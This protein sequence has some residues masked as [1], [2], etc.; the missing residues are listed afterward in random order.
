MLTELTEG[1]SNTDAASVDTASFTPAVGQLFFITGKRTDSGSMASDDWVIT[2]TGSTWDLVTTRLFTGTSAWRLSVYR[3]SAAG[4]AAVAAM[5]V[6]TAV[7][8]NR[9][10]WSVQE[11]SAPLTG[12]V[13]QSAVAS[14]TFSA[15]AAVTLAA[16]ADAGNWT[17]MFSSADS[18]HTTTFED[19]TWTALTNIDNLVGAFKE[20]EDTSPT[21]TLSGNRSWGAIG[22]EL[23]ASTGA[24]A[25]V[26]GTLATGTKTQAD[27][28]AGGQT[29]ILTLTGDTFLTPFDSTITAAL[30]AGVDAASSPATGWNTVVRDAAV[31]PIT[32]VRTSATVATGTLAA[33]PSYAI[34]ADEV[35]TVTIPASA[36][37]GGVAIIA[38]PTITIH[39]GAVLSAYSGTTNGSGVL[40][41][42][43]T[44]DQAGILVLTRAYIGAT[45]VG[46]ITT[47]PT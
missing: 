36:L 9:R 32:W 44:S 45:E 26:T 19:G 2:Q 35:L 40:A 25:A 18:T 1:T 11:P 43:L 46:R 47:L 29:I 16:F 28:K 21:F 20:S 27:V 14:N 15:S 3:C 23:E 13:V 33:N 4:S 17:V 34:T 10:K 7:N 39:E 30:T 6:D 22:L 24:T 5:S 37:T 31:N 12:T 8:M 41:V 38:T 42:N